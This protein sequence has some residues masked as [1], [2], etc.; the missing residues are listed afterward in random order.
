MVEARLGLQRWA[1]QAGNRSQGRGSGT[2]QKG[3][4]ERTRKL[5]VPAHGKYGC[6]CRARGLPCTARLG[7]SP[8]RGWQ[9]L[10]GPTEFYA[11]CAR[12]NDTWPSS[13]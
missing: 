3:Q 13:Q 6:R 7:R 10:K 2:V 1:G 8:T 4:S 5:R 9:L 12:I 11:I